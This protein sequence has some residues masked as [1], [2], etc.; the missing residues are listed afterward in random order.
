MGETLQWHNEEQT[1]Q[2]PFPKCGR[3][4][5]LIFIDA[6]RQAPGDTINV[7]CVIFCF[8]FFEDRNIKDM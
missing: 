6:D 5:T 4:Q 3:V 8:S 2:H 1:L 7:V